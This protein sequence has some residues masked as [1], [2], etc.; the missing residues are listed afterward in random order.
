VRSGR[1]NRA[2]REAGNVRTENRGTT[3]T[4]PAGFV[5]VTEY[6]DG[7]VAGILKITQRRLKKRLGGGTVFYPS[8]T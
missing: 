3:R 5:R 2:E 8:D 1:T 4:S 7:E 6:P